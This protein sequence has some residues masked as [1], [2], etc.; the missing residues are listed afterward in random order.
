MAR[1]S[2]LALL[3]VG[4]TCSSHQDPEGIQLSLFGDRR[5][6]DPVFDQMAMQCC[7][8]SADEL[9]HDNCYAAGGTEQDRFTCDAEFLACMALWGVPPSVAEARYRAVR[10]WGD[11]SFHYT[12]ERT[13]GPAR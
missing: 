3:L 8:G 6:S 4:A 1:L 11:E 13:R 12:E 9:G 7:V 2:V 10:R 5:C